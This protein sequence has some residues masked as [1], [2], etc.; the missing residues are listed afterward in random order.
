MKSVCE[1][2]AHKGTIHRIV[3]AGCGVEMDLFLMGFALWILLYK[4][5]KLAETFFDSQICFKVKKE[6][7]AEKR[8]YLLQIQ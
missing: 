5:D 7:F 6:K 4:M 2:E 8:E 3:L 1:P